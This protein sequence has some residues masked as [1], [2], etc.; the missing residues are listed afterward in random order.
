MGVFF[1][2][3]SGCCSHQCEVQQLRRGSV[4]DCAECE[5]RAT[6]ECLFCLRNGVQHFICSELCL[7]SNRKDGSGSCVQSTRT[8]SQEYD[9]V[10]YMMQKMFHDTNP[11]L[12]ELNYNQIQALWVDLYRHLSRKLG[13][14][15][16]SS[17]V[18]RLSFSNRL[19]L[20]NS[21]LSTAT[22]KQ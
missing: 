17:N 15:C 1:S 6:F 10:K 13:L 18:T 14:S 21:V 7:L 20:R 16:K 8:T 11:C 9:R 12:A 22:G 4:S 3:V 5:K 19:R 2:G